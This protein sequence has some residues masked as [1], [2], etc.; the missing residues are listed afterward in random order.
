VYH[1]TTAEGLKGIIE[2][3]CI[4]ATNVNFLNDISE[5]HHG[6]DIVRG[7]IKEYEVKPETLLAA[8]IEPTSLA[9]WLAKSIIIGNI[10]RQMEGVDYSLRSFVASFFDSPA[11]PTETAATDAGDILEQ[12]R[13]YGRDSVAVSI[14]FDKS[15]LAQHVSGFDYNI[16]ALWTIAGACSYELEHKKAEH[17]REYQLY[18]FREAQAGCEDGV[19]TSGRAAL[20]LRQDAQAASHAGVSAVSPVAGEASYRPQPR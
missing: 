12:W 17:I 1:Y 11:P 4:W 8:N 19:T 15:A 13:A 18:L 5:Y 10:Q 2:F 3:R 9:H 7:E 16:T 20:L 6:I 14:G